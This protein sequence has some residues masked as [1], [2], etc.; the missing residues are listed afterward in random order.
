MSAKYRHHLTSVREELPQRD[1]RHSKEIVC[2]AKTKF[3]NRVFQKSFSYIRMYVYMKSSFPKHNLHN[4]HCKLF[5]NGAYRVLEKSSSCVYSVCVFVPECK[6]K[7]DYFYYVNKNRGWSFLFTALEK[8]NPNW[9][10][11]TLFLRNACIHVDCC[12][13]GM[14]H[15]YGPGEHGKLPTYCRWTRQCQLRAFI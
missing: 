7:T 11:E 2:N 12:L 4:W 10:I 5:F 1:K 14:L 3:A 15:S 6:I 8:K 9:G 13:W